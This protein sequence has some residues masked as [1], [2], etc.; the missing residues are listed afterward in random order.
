MTRARRVIALQDQ[1]IAKI[2]FEAS[3]GHRWVGSWSLPLLNFIF[4]LGLEV[5]WV[6]SAIDS[7]SWKSPRRKVGLYG[8]GF[9][10]SRSRSCRAPITREGWSLEDETE[11]AKPATGAN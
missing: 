11:D 6:L 2:A 5:R 4:P 10:N 8:S 9:T 7:I 1:G 3:H